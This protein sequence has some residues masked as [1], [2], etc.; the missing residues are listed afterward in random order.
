MRGKRLS[1]V[2]Y[3]VSLKM[4]ERREWGWPPGCER[5][6]DPWNPPAALV[7][8]LSVSECF[9]ALC[10]IGPSFLP[11]AIQSHF[12]QTAPHWD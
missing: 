4:A 10:G 5:S 6:N 9:V 1:G 11:Q 2:P 8:S 7:V 12:K 3:F